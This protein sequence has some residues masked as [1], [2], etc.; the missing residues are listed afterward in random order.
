MFNRHSGNRR[1]PLKRSKSQRGALRRLWLEPLEDRRLLAVVFADSFEESEW[2]G[3]WVEDGQNDWRRSSSRSSD[4]SYAAEVDG[5]AA[6]AVLTMANPLDM[7]T[8]TSAELSFSWFIEK[9]WD[10]GE[11]IALDL[12][13]GNSW[14]QGVATLQ[15]NIDQENVWH[16][17]TITID[18]NYLVDGFNLRF[19][20]SVS[21]GQEDGYVDNVQIDG[22]AGTPVEPVQVFFLLGQSNV[23]GY[24]NVDELPTPLDAPQSD[25]WIWQ[26]D[27]GANVGWTS[28]RGGFAGGSVYNHSASGDNVRFGPEISLGRTLADSQPGSHFAIV[29][30]TKAGSMADA[31]SPDRGGGTGPGANWTAFINR[32][33]DALAELSANQTSYEVAG[34][35]VPEGGPD[36][37]DLTDAAN[38]QQ[39]LTAFIDGVR[40]EFGEPDLPILAWQ[41]NDGR[42]TGDYHDGWVQVRQGK[43]AVAAADPLVTMVH[44]DDLSRY[45]ET[46][47]DGYHYDSEGQLILGTRLGDA[48]FGQP[49]EG[50][51]KAGTDGFESGDFGGGYEQWSSGAWSVSGDVSVTPTDPAVVTTMHQGGFEAELLGNSEMVRGVD[52]TG[53]SNVKLRL[54]SRRDAFESSDTASVQVSGDGANWTTLLQHVDGEDNNVA[55]FYELDVPNLGNTLYVRFDAEMDGLDDY[56]YVDSVKLVGTTPAGPP[57]N[58]PTITSSANLTA[59]QD[60]LYSYDVEATD[61]D[62]GDTLTYSLDTAPAGMTIDANSGLIQWTPDNSQVG[63]NAVTVR[64]Q[65]DGGLS[66]TQNFSITVANV[67]D[68]PTITSLPVTTASAESLYSYDVEAS[69]P[70]V[71]DTLVYSLDLAP[72]GMA[73]DS[74]SGLIQWTP[75]SG[76]VG[77]HSVTVRVQDVGGLFATQPFSIDV[78]DVNHAPTIDSTAATGATEDSLYTYDGEATDIDPGDTLTYSLDV[79][80]GGMTIDSATGLIGW[81]PANSQVGANSVTVRVADQLGAFDTQSFT[82]TVANTNDLPTITSTPVTTGTEGVVYTYDV[83]SVDPDIGDTATYSL[84]VAPSGMTIDP[85]HGDH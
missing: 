13:D 58:A 14:T 33:N 15:G 12:Y 67:N 69:D 57:N 47:N 85:Q 49:V 52:V 20:S 21:A 45:Q 48:Y 28:L 46:K 41:P 59:T 79:A 6:D 17:E 26:D 32:A 8:Y 66:D 37:R 25:V 5:S 2:N 39:N 35:L 82:I 53:L 10:R 83:E 61:A 40:Q 56:W 65:D 73:I 34:L 64:V 27:L 60:L 16:H 68:A 72:I 71:G 18:S 75:T 9:S 74:G 54:Y 3:R 11:Y 62:V 70:D 77:S 30:Y 38:Y 76:Q 80:P 42:Q 78:A 51:A 84:D 7:A 19:R 4:G 24:G 29:K 36:A 50:S 44:T 22:T 81:T 63:A 31:W 23:S 55:E 1:R 43:E